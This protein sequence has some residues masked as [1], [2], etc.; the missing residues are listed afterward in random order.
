M[1]QISKVEI[2]KVKRQNQITKSQIINIKNE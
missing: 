2:Y 1:E